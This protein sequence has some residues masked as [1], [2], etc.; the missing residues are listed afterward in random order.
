MPYYSI[1][2]NARN[3]R[4]NVL[5]RASRASISCAR[6]DTGKNVPSIHLALA[7]KSGNGI[8]GRNGAETSCPSFS[9]VFMP[10][11]SHHDGTRWLIDYGRPMISPMAPR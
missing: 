1:I 4:R 8:C 7:V 2:M 9:S 5:F 11:H 10:K 6:A 3:Q